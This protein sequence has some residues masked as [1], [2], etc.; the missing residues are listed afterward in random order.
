VLNCACLFLKIYSRLGIQ[1]VGQIVLPRRVSLGLSFWIFLPF[2]MISSIIII[3][4]TA[5]KTITVDGK[6]LCKLR[7]IHFVRGDEG[8]RIPRIV[9]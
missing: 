8:Q 1:N 6:H 4:M 2:A 7:F 3:I 9:S 5:T